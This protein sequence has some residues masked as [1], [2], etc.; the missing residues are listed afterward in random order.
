MKPFFDVFVQRHDSGCFRALL[1]YVEPGNEAAPPLYVSG[2]HSTAQAAGDEVKPHLYRH[3]REIMGYKHPE[4][5][6]RTIFDVPAPPGDYFRMHVPG[7]EP[8]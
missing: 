1:L 2:N 8:T 4:D 6:S 5:P 3:W 7:G